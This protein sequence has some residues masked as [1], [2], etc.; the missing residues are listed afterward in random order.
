MSHTDKTDPAFVQA[1]DR[2]L[3][4]VRTKHYGP[5]SARNQEHGF[6]PRFY[7]GCNEPN[8]SGRAERKNNNRK[9]RAERRSVA[10]RA[11]STNPDELDA[12]AALSGHRASYY[13]LA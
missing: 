6:E 9:V 5:D 3:I 12:P 11:L 1:T 7:G 13:G 2:T 10:R 4:R 8:L